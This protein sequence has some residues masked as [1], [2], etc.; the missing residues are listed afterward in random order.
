MKPVLKVK[1]KMK[2]SQWYGLQRK[3]KRHH[4]YN[5]NVDNNN[6]Q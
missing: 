4:K 3:D 6:K 5:V 1:V 2:P